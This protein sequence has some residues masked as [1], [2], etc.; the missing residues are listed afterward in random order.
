MAKKTKPPPQDSTIKKEP[1]LAEV[2]PLFLDIR[3]P[4]GKRVKFKSKKQ[5]K[6]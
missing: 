6:T 3:T 5:G 4:D 2:K 1:K